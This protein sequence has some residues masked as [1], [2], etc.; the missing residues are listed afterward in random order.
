MNFLAHFFLSGTE[1][2]ALTTGNFLGDFI[3][4]KKYQLYSP[5]IQKGILLHRQI[6]SFTD[7]HPQVK[8][9]KRRLYSR[10]HHYSAVLV[11]LYYDHFLAARFKDYSPQ[12]LPAFEL[13]VYKLLEQ[14][15]AILTEKARFLSSNMR[16]GNWLS[17]YG[18]MEGITSAI[19]GTSRISLNASIIES[20]GEELQAQY[21][22]LE[23]DFRL[24]MP[25][26]QAYVRNWLEE[27][28]EE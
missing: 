11:D 18:T 5:S 19:K 28:Q 16:R 8:K 12:P 15:N 17:R 6:D 9:S 7:H 24:F 4:G 1:N 27:N 10:Y 2:K 13:E 23:E 3:K 26:I 20:G 25:D 22:F 14:E 21:D